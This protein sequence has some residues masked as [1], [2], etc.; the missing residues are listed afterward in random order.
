VTRRSWDGETPVVGIDIDGTLGRYHEHFLR[1][2][3]EWVGLTEEY[4]PGPPSVRDKRTMTGGPIPWGDDSYDGSCSLAEYMGVSK[5]TYRLCKLAYRRGGLKRSM[6]LYPGARELLVA[7]RRRAWVVLCTT[8]PYLHLDNIEPDTVEWLRRN[9][10]PYDALLMG[11]HKYRDL[12]R[13]YGERV[14]AVLDDDPALLSQARGLSPAIPALFM[15]RGHNTYAWDCQPWWEN[16]CDGARVTLLEH[17]KHGFWML[18][19]QPKN[20]DY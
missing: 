7:L 1:F 9:R 8:R 5:R 11:E 3:R 17:L 6:P 14:A 19:I 16:S 4:W 10:M 2:A 12:R 13:Q 20:G 18:G 15:V